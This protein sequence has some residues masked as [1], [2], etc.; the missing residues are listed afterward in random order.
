MLIGLCEMGSWTPSVPGYVFKS[1]GPGHPG[2]GWLVKN[3]NSAR[4]HVIPGLNRR[5]SRLRF[6]PTTVWMVHGPPCND[7]PRLQIFWR[8][9]RQELL[10]ERDVG[11]ANI[12]GGDWNAVTALEHRRS[13]LQ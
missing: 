12:L 11:Q 5:A 7:R 2:L 13:K 9:I 1:A 3:A 6:G 4:A 10:S 8:L